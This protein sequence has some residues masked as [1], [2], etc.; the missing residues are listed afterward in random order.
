MS[1]QK[2][3]PVPLL[4]WSPSLHAEKGWGL[5]WST[6]DGVFVRPEK[7]RPDAVPLI[8]RGEELAETERRLRE[9]LAPDDDDDGHGPWHYTGFGVMCSCHHS[10]DNDERCMRPRTPEGIEQERAGA[11]FEAADNLLTERKQRP[12]GHA[13]ESSYDDLQAALDALSE[14]AVE[15]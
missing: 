5:C 12:G 13:R 3:Q 9:G 15:L 4:W 14:L 2:S 1:G 8:P 10:L 11:L 7:L 6:V